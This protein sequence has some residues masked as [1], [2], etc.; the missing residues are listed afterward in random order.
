MVGALLPASHGGRPD[1]YDLD[2]GGIGGIHPRQ[3]QDVAYKGSARRDDA[4]AA[5]EFGLLAVAGCAFGRHNL[6]TQ[7]IRLPRHSGHKH[8]AAARVDRPVR[9]AR[10]VRAER[11]AELAAFEPRHPADMAHRPCQVHNPLYRPSPHPHRIHMR[12]P[13][14]R[15]RIFSYHADLHN[16]TNN[17]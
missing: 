13:L 10:M 4:T 11:T 17:Q 3:V 5:A 1:L 12:V 2:S 9:M 15:M 16:Q 14:T 7:H 8:D 6:R